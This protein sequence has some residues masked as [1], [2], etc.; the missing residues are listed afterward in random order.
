MPMRKL[1]FAL[2]ALIPLF[3]LIAA[4]GV[5]ALRNASASVPEAPETLPTA[6][7]TATPAPTATAAPTATPT[8]TPTPT[9]TL[10]TLPVRNGTPV[11]D[12]P[13]EVITAENVHR[14][15]EVARYGYPRLLD[16]NPYRL[17]ADGKTIVVGT[18]AGIE[19]YDAR[20][21]AKNGGFEVDFLRAFDMSPD[22]RFILTRAGDTLT[23]WRQDGQKVR[24]FALEA[25]DA[26]ALNAV[27]LSP[28]GSLLAVQRKKTDWQE[29][30]KLDVYR[31]EDGS[32]VDTV[33]GMG[34]QFSPDGKYLATVF[35]A[36]VRLYPV[37]ELGQG[38]EKRLPRQTLPWCSGGETCGLV[39]SPD[40]TLAA[41]VRAGRVDVYQVETRQ[42]VRQVSGWEV[43]D[44]YTL[45]SVQFTP[46]GGQ[47]LITTQPLYNSQG[48]VQA[49][50][51]TILVNV[52][53]GEWVVNQDAP[54]GFAYPDGQT[55]RG[56]Q[57]QAEGEMPK[58]YYLDTFLSVDNEGNVLV[59]DSK[60]KCLNSI[61]AR[62]EK[63]EVLVIDNNGLSFAEVTR[64]DKNIIVNRNSS[65]IQIRED[66]NLDEIQVAGNVVIANYHKGRTT[67]TIVYTRDKKYQISDWVMNWFVSDGMLVINT[68]QSGV[69]LLDT[70]NWSVNRLNL[71]ENVVQFWDETITVPNIF[72]AN[73]PSINLIS[74]KK[75]VPS[76]QIP[77]EEWK[78]S[79][80]GWIVHSAAFSKAG[81]ILMVE[82]GNGGVYAINVVSNKQVFSKELYSQEISSMAFSPNG[83]FFATYGNDGF[84]RVWAVVP[85]DAPVR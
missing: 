6:T 58:F 9:P 83:Q 67:W 24:E 3:L 70:V 18:T 84:I 7:A 10:I 30:D 4:A 34:A 48:E 25:G 45:P 1:V 5:F 37:A 57:W 26:W 64:S 20:T 61:C 81:N 72:G 33:R 12:L 16:Q 80:S 77:V 29:P 39:F 53:S 60:I 78:M 55:V 23:V 47:L 21:Q 82:N 54:E 36:S 28:D 43:L 46:Q 63:N 41:V 69:I 8:A 74:L 65:I 17:T 42:L 59:S 52:A 19:F 56:F 79:R 13:Y 31:V 35:D 68:F 51:K 73:S 49:K 71:V 14:L 11:P 62:L 66:E 44:T 85:E 22:G 2:Y 38:W 27:A 15:R 50:A 76:I 32:L 75:S 40:G